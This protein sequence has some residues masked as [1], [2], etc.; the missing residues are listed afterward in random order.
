[1][2]TEDITASQP[3]ISFPFASCLNGDEKKLSNWLMA[4]INKRSCCSK[5]EGNNTLAI[6]RTEKKQAKKYGM[7]RKQGKY[8]GR[9]IA[10]S[11]FSYHD[12]FKPEA[13]DSNGKSEYGKR[14]VEFPVNRLFEVTGYHDEYK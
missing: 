10:D 14:P 9:V 8:A 6:K 3:N 4:S 5:K 13:Q 7:S 11:N 2:E 12:L 1:M